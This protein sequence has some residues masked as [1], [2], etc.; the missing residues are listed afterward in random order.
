MSPKDLVLTDRD[1]YTALS[2]AAINGTKEMVKTMVE[3]NKELVL[4]CDV[5]ELPV[6]T[7]AWHENM[8]MVH[9]LYWQTPQ[10][11]LGPDKGKDGAT[12]LTKSIISDLFDIALDLLKRYPTLATSEDYDGRNAITVLARKPSAFHSGRFKTRETKSE[13]LALQVLKIISTQVSKMDDKQLK[14]AG[15]Y[16]AVLE[17]TKFGIVEF[18]YEVMKCNRHM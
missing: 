12:L 11:L 1:G 16:E 4:V 17:A 5:H 14:D 9:Y 10:E 8:D 7:A 18:V 2:L 6:I 3:K 13:L 15:V